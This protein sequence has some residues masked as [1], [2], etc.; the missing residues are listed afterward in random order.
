MVRNAP[1]L[2]VIAGPNGAGKSTIALLRERFDVR[3]FV[4]A[5]VIAQGLSA[6]APESV[7]FAAGRVMLR[8]LRELADARSDFAF[9]TTL[10]SRSFAPWIAGLKVRGYVF[11]LVF[12]W[13][14]DAR[15]AA[16]RVQLRVAAGGH[17]IPAQVVHRRFERS[18]RNFFELYR[19]IADRW[20]VYDNSNPAGARV[21]ARGSGPEVAEVLDT[22]CWR[23]IEPPTDMIRESAPTPSRFPDA[24]A[25]DRV[26]ARAVREALWRH[27][28]LGQSIVAWQEGR[29][30]R[31]EAKDIPVDPP[32]VEGGDA[33]RTTSG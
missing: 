10:A 5:D 29:I 6:F 21:I 3:E 11:D 13:L 22:N 26:V 20:T 9:E 8:R 18:R 12:V 2:I 1:R 17:S 30:V 28:Q 14:R 31:I 24:E 16:E 4:N 27:K 25:M 19:P 33:R 15:L 23:G 7:A 32:D